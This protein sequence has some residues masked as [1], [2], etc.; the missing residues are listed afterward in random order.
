MARPTIPSYK[1]RKYYV[2]IY[3]NEHEY[4][5]VNTV[6]ERLLID[7][8][9]LHYTDLLRLLIMNLDESMIAY[10]NLPQNDTIRTKLLLDYLFSSKNVHF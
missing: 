8:P 5:H 6:K 9:A 4:N 1:K 2:K 10:L 7:S 3:L